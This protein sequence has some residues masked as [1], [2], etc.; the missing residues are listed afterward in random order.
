MIIP[1]KIKKLI[2]SESFE[3]DTVG[4]SDSSVFLFEDKV[5]K[6]RTITQEAQNEVQVMRW[7]E[8]KLP[9]PEVLACE[10]SDGSSYLLM[11]RIPGAMACEPQYME[12]PAML[13]KLLAQALKRLWSVDI[14][15]CPCNVSLENKLAQAE[16]R[17]A[18]NMVDVEDAEPDTFGDNGFESPQALLA[19]LKENQPMEELV[20]IHGDYCLPNVFFD[21]ESLTGFI[22]LGRMGIGD[23][24]C[25]IALCY[26]SLCHNFEGRYGGKPYLGFVPQMLFEELGIE[27]DWE[28]LRYYILLDELF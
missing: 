12:Q 3:T 9:V 14:T 26:R 1:E 6:I 27:P 11:S 21:G 2:D 5:L 22:D 8:G 28:R 10:E 4:K 13:V 24:W 16:E 17:V 23:K 7:L 15:D 25:D 20:L 18:K 19:W